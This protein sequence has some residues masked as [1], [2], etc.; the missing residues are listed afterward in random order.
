MSHSTVVFPSS[1]PVFELLPEG[2]DCRQW[3]TVD[4]VDLEHVAESLHREARW[5]CLAPDDA[6]AQ[7]LEQGIPREASQPVG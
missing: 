5:Q 7:W 2:E 1:Y 6:A 4:R 3:P